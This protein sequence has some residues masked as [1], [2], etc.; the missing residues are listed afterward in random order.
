VNPRVALV[1]RKGRTLAFVDVEASIDGKLVAS[2]RVTKS[3]VANAL[4]A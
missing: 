4:Q 2:A 3:I 1:R